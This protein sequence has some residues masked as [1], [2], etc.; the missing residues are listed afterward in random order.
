[1]NSKSRKTKSAAH[2]VKVSNNLIQQSQALHSHVVAIQFD[3]EIIEVWDGGKQDAYLCIGL[4]VQILMEQER[5]QYK[6]FTL[7]L[8]EVI[9][10]LS[11]VYL[12]TCLSFCLS[13]CLLARLTMFLGFDI[14]KC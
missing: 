11:S 5:I 14:R 10:L 7:M 1:M 13:A 4:V 8:S 12:S 2:L 9:H 3:V 6:I